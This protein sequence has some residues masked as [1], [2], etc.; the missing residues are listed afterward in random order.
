MDTLIAN[1]ITIV[2]KFTNDSTYN[3]EF[4]VTRVTVGNIYY[5]VGTILITA[6]GKTY[7]TTIPYTTLDVAYASEDVVMAMIK[8]DFV[9]RYITQTSKHD[10]LFTELTSPLVVPAHNTSSDDNSAYSSPIKSRSPSPIKSRKVR[11]QSPVRRDFSD[12]DRKAKTES[13]WKA[14]TNTLR[15]T[16][17]DECTSEVSKISEDDGY[18]DYLCV[19]EGEF[20]HVDLPL[21]DHML[22]MDHDQDYADDVVIIQ[23]YSWQE[24]ELLAELDDELDGY[25]EKCNYETPIIKACMEIIE[26]ATPNT[27]SGRF[28]IDKIVLHAIKSLYKNIKKRTDP[29]QY[30]YVRSMVTRALGMIHP[31]LLNYPGVLGKCD[32]IRK[33]VAYYENK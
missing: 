4:D 26:V 24:Q 2:G 5:F 12:D 27:L 33:V 15:Y 3:A 20:T 17:A 11:C 6:N 19:D 29:Y 16:P 1:Y 18:T 10:A 7:I 22:P 31:E 23:R 28:T 9:A 32:R 21:C 13:T 8:S 25:F 14:V 30:A